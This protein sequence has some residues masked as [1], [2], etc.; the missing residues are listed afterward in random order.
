MIHALTIDVEDYHSVTARDWQKGDCRPTRAVVENTQRLLACLAD[1]GVRATFFVLGEVAETF[2]DGPGDCGA[3]HEL[4]VTALSWQVFKL[5]QRVFGVRSSRQAAHRRPYRDGGG[6]TSS[7]GV[8]D[9]AAD[10]LVPGDAG[11]IWGFDNSE[12]V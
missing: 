3:G 4:G 2:P 8:L 10:K 7:A 6:G 1:H 12:R 9:H 11:S 5:R